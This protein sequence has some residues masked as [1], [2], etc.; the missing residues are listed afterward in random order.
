MLNDM[1]KQKFYDEHG[2]ELDLS[3]PAL[4]KQDELEAKKV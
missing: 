2:N 3:G 1:K 4:R